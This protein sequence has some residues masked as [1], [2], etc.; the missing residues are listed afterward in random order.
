[1]QRS[2]LKCSIGCSFDSKGKTRLNLTQSQ[3][4]PPQVRFKY[5]IL[6]PALY[7][8]NSIHPL[9]RFPK[10]LARAALEVLVRLRRRVYHSSSSPALVC[11]RSTSVYYINCSLQV[12]ITSTAV[13]KYVLHQLQPAREHLLDTNAF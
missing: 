8:L 13:W 5:L 2:A 3:Y 10:Q 11:M 9:L 6:Y 4:K 7:I 12:S 1:M